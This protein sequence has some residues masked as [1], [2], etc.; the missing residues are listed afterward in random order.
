MGRTTVVRRIERLGLA[1]GNGIVELLDARFEGLGVD[2]GQLG[3]FADGVGLVDRTVQ[4]FESG[5]KLRE[6]VVF[7]VGLRVA[8]DER[9]VVRRHLR[10]QLG[11]NGL[12]EAFVHATAAVLAHDH[13]VSGIAHAGGIG[14]RFGDDR[15]GIE[16]GQI[17]ELRTDGFR[18]ENVFTRGALGAAQD[19]AGRP[20][21]HVGR[22]QFF[23]GGDSS[24]SEFREFGRGFS[25]H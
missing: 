1:R 23:V 16:F 3:E 7:V 22:A 15:A 14:V 17:D 11:A 19:E 24:S 8:D 13:A 6:D 2:A 10:E 4:A 12:T 21:S 25:F 9:A 18:H 20:R 5:E